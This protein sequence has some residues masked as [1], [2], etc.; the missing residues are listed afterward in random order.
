MSYPNTTPETVLRR[1]GMEYP[2]EGPAIDHTTTPVTTS[3][4]NG[5]TP[6]SMLSGVM[7]K[8]NQYAAR[9]TPSYKTPTTTRVVSDNFDAPVYNPT[10]ADKEAFRQQEYAKYMAQL[11][12][13]KGRINTKKANAYFNSRFDESW[14]NHVTGIQQQQRDKARQERMAQQRQQFMDA[15]NNFSINLQDDVNAT[16]EAQH[17]KMNPETGEWESQTKGLDFNN[18]Q[19]VQEWLL[20]QGFKLN[21]YGADGHY[22]TETNDAITAMLNSKGIVNLSD[23]ERQKFMDLQSA[24]NNKRQSTTPT[25]PVAQQHVR[26][27][28]A[29]VSAQQRDIIKGNDNLRYHHGTATKQLDYNGR[30]LPLVVTTGLGVGNWYNDQS[31]WYDAENDNYILAKEGVFG[32]VKGYQTDANGNPFTMTWDQIKSGTRHKQGGTLIKKHQQGGNMDIQSQVKQLVQAVAAG[33]QQAAEQVKQIMAAAEQGDQQALQI[34]Q[35]IQAEIEAI[36]SAKRGAKLNYIKS[37]RGDCPDGEEVVYFKKGGMLCK[38][39]QK[40]HEKV[41]AAKGKKMNAI[42]EFKNRK[43]C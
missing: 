1:P 9:Y 41:V 22:G 11:G 2:V 36:K 38:E 3:S 30:K 27:P 28:V 24:W 13:G 21:K 39:C 43:K 26:G 33:D 14:N 32:N 40:K 35:M 37:L 29:E 6:G 7:N 12:Q 5:Y 10:D 34:A 19:A 4:T 25:T 8:A 23:E 42:D 17:L 15:A 16:R 18:T 20:K 31:F